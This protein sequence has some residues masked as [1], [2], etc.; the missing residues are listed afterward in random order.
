MS[1]IMKTISP[2]V[3]ILN[4]FQ[5]RNGTFH[6]VLLRHKRSLAKVFEYNFAKYMRNVSILFK[7]REIENK[8]Y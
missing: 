6:L 2:L 5:F 8:K 7:K 4:K 3:R 1:T